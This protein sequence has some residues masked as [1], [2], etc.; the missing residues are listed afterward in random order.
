MSNVTLPNQ[1]A[2]VI[3]FDTKMDWA[4]TIPFEDL[5]PFSFASTL[6]RSVTLT[7]GNKR[8]ENFGDASPLYSPV[9]AGMFSDLPSRYRQSGLT[10]E[11]NM[12]LRALWPS[13]SPSYLG[14]L[15][16]WLADDARFSQST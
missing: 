14:N 9:D 7:T 6:E 15:P 10:L 11:G 13:E 3:R 16:W 1:A 4:V 8:I 12:N 2:A 5:T